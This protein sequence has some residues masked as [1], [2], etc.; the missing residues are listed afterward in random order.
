MSDYIPY[1]IAA[2]FLYA[3]M[4]TRSAPAAVKTAD[5]ILTGV[6]VPG[7]YDMQK[8]VH[9][10]RHD[11]TGP[12]PTKNISGA[13][14]PPEY[15]SIATKR[16]ATRP[17]GFPSTNL[18]GFGNARNIEPIETTEDAIQMVPVE[19]LSAIAYAV[20]DTAYPNLPSDALHRTQNSN[21]DEE[22]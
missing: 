14:L 7:S 13:I 5:R 9:S 12:K 18:S 19:H 4:N 8:A 10:G 3:F 22:Y 15:H 16:G 11:A 20:P 17:S 21:Q 2:F 6:S 1:G